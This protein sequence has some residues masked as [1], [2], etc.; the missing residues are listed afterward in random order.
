MKKE[1]NDT[2]NANLGRLVAAM[3]MGFAMDILVVSE[4]RKF[5]DELMKQGAKL[6]NLA[7]LCEG[8]ITAYAALIYDSNDPEEI[9]Q[10]LIARNEAEAP[11]LRPAA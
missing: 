1:K 9:R 4:D 10:A 7:N 2:A 11:K 6:D 5:T 3:A 8:A